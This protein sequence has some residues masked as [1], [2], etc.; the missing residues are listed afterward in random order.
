MRPAPFFAIGALLT[1]MLG[2]LGPAPGKFGVPNDDPSGAPPP[3]VERCL[4]L[5]YEPAVAGRWM[6]A[7][8][9]LTVVAARVFDRPGARGY[10]AVGGPDPGG[11]M[12]AGWRAAGPDS[13]DIG[14][15]HSPL[16]RLPARRGSPGETLIGRGGW[17]D[18]ATFYS[19]MV[20]EGDFMV[21]AVEVACSPPGH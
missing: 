8:I 3:S 9:R 14:W 16:I 17:W 12:F 19:A 4:V 21:H 20:G 18:Y 1:L 7:T 2:F 5:S 11:Y 15:H 10:Q 6:P 13:I